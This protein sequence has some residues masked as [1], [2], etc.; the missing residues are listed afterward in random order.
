[1]ESI[2]R[3]W[4]QKNAG[5]VAPKFTQPFKVKV[6]GC[7]YEPSFDHL[8]ACGFPANPLFKSTKPSSVFRKMGTDVRPPVGP[9]SVGVFLWARY[10]CSLLEVKGG[11][12]DFTSCRPEAHAQWTAL[13]WSLLYI[14]TFAPDASSSFAT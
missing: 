12:S 9:K 8:S 3:K 5:Y 11:V 13:H 4:S 1:M 2:H 6:S 10:P 7:I 14:C